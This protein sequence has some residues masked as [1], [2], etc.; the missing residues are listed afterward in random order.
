MRLDFGYRD[1]THEALEDLLRK[2][3]HLDRVTHLDVFDNQIGDEGL[4]A[5]I[6]ALYAAQS[7][8][9]SLDIGANQILYKRAQLRE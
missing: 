8:L 3:P 4:K 9:Q 2:T 6:D 5:L 7:P 1:L